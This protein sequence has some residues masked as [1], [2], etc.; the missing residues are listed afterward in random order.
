MATFS[1]L[2]DNSASIHFADPVE[3]FALPEKESEGKHQQIQSISKVYVC[4]IFAGD[5]NFGCLSSQ[6]ANTEVFQRNLDVNL[7]VTTAW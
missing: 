7:R 1:L 4:L 6:R 5:A 3:A 2:T